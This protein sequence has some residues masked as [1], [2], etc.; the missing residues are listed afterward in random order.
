MT[1]FPTPTDI[2]SAYDDEQPRPADMAGDE[3]VKVD[4]GDSGLDAA[5]QLRRENNGVSKEYIIK[6]VLLGIQE[7]L[8]NPNPNSPA[9]SE[10]YILFIND[11][12]KYNVKI[13]EETRKNPVPR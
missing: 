5:Q 1:K 4:S 2:M 11:R 10:P 13:Q 9:Q 3:C 6:E 12:E 7:L 8:N